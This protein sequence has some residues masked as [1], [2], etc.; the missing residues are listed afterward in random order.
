MKLMQ[1]K[2]QAQRRHWRVRKRVTGSAERPR[3]SLHFSNEHIYAQCVNDDEGK[4]LV[5]LS[6]LSVE[7]RRA[8]VR[9]NVNGAV[10]LGEAFGQLA[11][12]KGIRSVV[13]DRGS[14]R[15]HGCVKAFADAARKSGLE[16]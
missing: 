14:R 9:A 10:T 7:I 2:E 13:F 11:H 12:G 5:A 3:L 8:N 16:F 4:T 6:S 15:Y 1:K